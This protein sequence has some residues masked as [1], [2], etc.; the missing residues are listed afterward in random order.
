MYIYCLCAYE[1]VVLLLLPFVAFHAVIVDH[2]DTA[3][4]AYAM[5][6]C[7][8]CICSTDMHTYIHTYLV[9]A[10]VVA[11]MSLSVLG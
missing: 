8:N 4:V 7:Y 2:P 3:F 11:V 9:V 6:R 10:V 5:C 1:L